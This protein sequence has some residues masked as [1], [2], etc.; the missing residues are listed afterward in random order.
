MTAVPA[1]A[2]KTGRTR[3]H[4]AA[5]NSPI[6]SRVLAN[7][8]GESERPQDVDDLDA[9][10]KVVKVLLKNSWRGKKVKDQV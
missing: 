2:G 3:H 6:V 5:S 1:K 7:T 8:D 9:Q 4:S 10:V